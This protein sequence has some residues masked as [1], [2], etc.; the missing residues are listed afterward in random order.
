MR[1]R[2]HLQ[3]VMGPKPSALTASAAGKVVEQ[4]EFSHSFLVGMG[5]GTATWR[6]AWQFLTEGKIDLS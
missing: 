6:T 5:F 3:P 2:L 1:V 4:R